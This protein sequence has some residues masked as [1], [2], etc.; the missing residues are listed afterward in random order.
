MMLLFMLIL[1]I[2]I[3]AHIYALTWRAHRQTNETLL[4]GYRA[5]SKA[6]SRHKIFLIIYNDYIIIYANVRGMQVR[7]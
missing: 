4:V 7:F 6:I 3:H 5:Y 2:Q 1:I